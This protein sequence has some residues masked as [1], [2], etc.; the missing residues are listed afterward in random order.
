M[1]QT[2]MTPMINQRVPTAALTCGE[3]LVP[4]SVRTSCQAMEVQA[5]RAF[6]DV[7]INTSERVRVTGIVRFIV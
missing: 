2:R 6:H 5:R 3:M 7:R 1:L 4:N